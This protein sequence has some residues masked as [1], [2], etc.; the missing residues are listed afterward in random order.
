MML[1]LGLA[2]IA[3][4]VAL[5]VGVLVY[6][7]INVVAPAPTDVVNRLRRVCQA[8]VTKATPK[9]TSQAS[10]MGVS[11]LLISDEPVHWLERVLITMPW[12]LGLATLIHQTQPTHRLPLLLLGLG[13]APVVGGLALGLM[14]QNILMPLLACLIPLGT[15]TVLVQLRQRRFDKILAQFPG[16]LMVLAGALRAG[17]AFPSAL[18][19]A[20]TET[21][22]PLGAELQGM[23]Q[24]LSLG[25]PLER[26]L[27]K[28]LLRV[29]AMAD[30]QL[31]A[32]AVTLQHE[33]GGNL[34]EVLDNLT[35]TIRLRFKLQQHIASVTAQSR[36]TGYLMGAAPSIVLGVLTLFFYSY[37][38]ALYENPLGNLGL[39][40]ALLLQLLGLFTIRK[41][42]DIRY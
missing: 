2:I 31:F 21:P 39:A 13:V 27:H 30:F 29:N 35:Q 25:L 34:A 4:L 3:V 7:S 38:A 11:P 33:T 41:L 36:M 8:S 1:L 24:D 19:L 6:Q 40:L 17:H 15:F 12:G 42:I 22:A 32:T 23:S 14:V 16:A 10:A 5:A 37:V 28:L 18:K 9:A 20:A 26:C